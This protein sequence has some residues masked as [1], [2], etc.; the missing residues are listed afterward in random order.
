MLVN[1][2]EAAEGKDHVHI[3]G[4]Q[5]MLELLLGISGAFR[6][7]VLTCLMGVS[8]AGKTTLMDVLAGRKTG[9]ASSVCLDDFLCEAARLAIMLCQACT[10]LKLA[11]WFTGC[12]STAPCRLFGAATAEPLRQ[13][14]VGKAIPS[15]L[16]WKFGVSSTYPSVQ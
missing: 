7:G 12:I 5:P 2:Q 4:S 13:R 14:S 6:P 9:T 1:V 15:L 10:A 16:W 3:E 11:N 8:G